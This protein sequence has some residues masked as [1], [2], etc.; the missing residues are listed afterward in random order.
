MTRARK[1]VPFAWLE[2]HKNFLGTECL[3]WP[4]S[5]SSRGY[6]RIRLNGTNMQVT[7]IMCAYR[8]GSPPTSKHEAAHSCGKGRFGCVN[9]QHL[10]WATAT[11]NNADRLVHGTHNKGEQNGR[12]KLS[13]ADVLAIRAVKGVL[14]RDLAQQY[15]VSFRTIAHVINYRSWVWL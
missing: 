1:G 5:R 2:L 14:H 6:G 4:F 13:E 7:R 10:R 11:E 8:H 3:M 9:P 12:A 15:G